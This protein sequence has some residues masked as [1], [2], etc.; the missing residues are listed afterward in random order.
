MTIVEKDVGRL[1]GVGGVVAA[2]CAAFCCAGAPIIVSMLA[3]AGLSFLRNDALLLPVI[4]VALAVA[5]WGFWRRRRTHRS[6]GPFV[7]GLIGSV[8]LV[9]G[10]VVLHGMLAKMFMAAGSLALLSAA[11][12]NALLPNACVAPLAAIR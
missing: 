5:L 3:A 12:W 7:V 4:G 9:A 11:I 8:A 10:V 6:L 1:A 2:T